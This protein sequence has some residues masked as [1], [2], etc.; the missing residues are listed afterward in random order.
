MKYGPQKGQAT[1]EVVLLLPDVHIIEEKT[2]SF[3]YFQA[4]APH[5]RIHP[6]NNESKCQKLSLQHKSGTQE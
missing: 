2:S 4:S 3:I 6:L 5:R 1:Q